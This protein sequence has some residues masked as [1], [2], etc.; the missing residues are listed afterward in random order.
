MV[1]WQLYVVQKKQKWV[2]GR[3]LGYTGETFDKME[4]I[5]GMKINL[6]KEEFKKQ[7][8]DIGIAIISQDKNIDPTYKELNALRDITDNTQSMPLI[9][10]SIMPKKLAS[11]ADCILLDVKCGKGAFMKSYEDTKKLAK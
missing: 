1:L 6:A 5:P 3:G 8:K 7:A 11:G 2:R 4:S 9:A 10:S